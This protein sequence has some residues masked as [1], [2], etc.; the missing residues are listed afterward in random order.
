[1]S[2]ALPRPH[3]RSR[4]R[5]FPAAA[6]QCICVDASPSTLHPP[7]HCFVRPPCHMPPPSAEPDR[8]RWKRTTPIISS[9]L[10]LQGL[11]KKTLLPIAT[12]VATDAGH[13]CSTNPKSLAVASMKAAPAANRNHE[14]CKRF[15]AT[16]RLLPTKDTTVAIVDRPCC[17]WRLPLLL[18]ASEGHPYCHRWALLLQNQVTDATRF[19][20]CAYFT[21]KQRLSLVP[22]LEALL[23]AI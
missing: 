19:A 4:R 13:G 8:R 9:R 20:P 21:S 7:C 15:R 12:A 23:Q 3:P 22:P 6:C 5:W 14:C 1:V 16:G 2:L 10:I 17:K 11:C 18:A